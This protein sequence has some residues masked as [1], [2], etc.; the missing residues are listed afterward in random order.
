MNSDVSATGLDVAL[1]IVLLCGVEYVAGC[2]Q[3]NNSSISSEILRSERAGVFGC[4]DG[5]SIL[6]SELSDRGDPD[7]DGGV[8]ESGRFGEYEYAGVILVSGGDVAGERSCEKR[9]CEKS[10]H[11][12][13]KAM[14]D[15]ELMGLRQSASPPARRTEDEKFYF[16]FC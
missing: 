13:L 10:L 15:D 2:V 8:A 1:E 12:R 3:E 7:S 14:R 5:E 4:V 6:L 16:L 11:G 9:E